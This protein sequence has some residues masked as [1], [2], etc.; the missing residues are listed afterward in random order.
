MNPNDREKT[1]F[2]TPFGTFEW[3]VMPFGLCN[4]PATFQSF[5]EEVLEPFRPFVA[6]LLDDVA[7]WAKDHHELHE[8]LMSIFSRFTEFGLILNSQKYRLFVNQ[9]IFLGFIISEKGIVADPKKVSAIKVRP[10]P[11]IN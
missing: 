5:M 4:A 6:E 1:A 2:V 10:M 3:L 9:G 7:V 11:L 8:R